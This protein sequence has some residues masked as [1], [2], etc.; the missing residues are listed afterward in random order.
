MVDNCVI[1]MY[2]L[3]NFYFSTFAFT[4]FIF[5]TRRFSVLGDK[6]FVYVPQRFLVVCV[7]CICTA[8][9]NS[10]RTTV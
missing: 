2:D 10:I 1:Y 9:T 8:I 7:I 6:H 4:I 5:C 3:L